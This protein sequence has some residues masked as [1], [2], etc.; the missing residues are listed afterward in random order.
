M[1]TKMQPSTISSPLPAT[2]KS[3][4]ILAAHPTK[5]KWVLDKTNV[6]S[7]NRKNDANQRPEKKKCDARCNAANAVRR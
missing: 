7:D 2:R 4:A 5:L 3:P 6:R 1:R